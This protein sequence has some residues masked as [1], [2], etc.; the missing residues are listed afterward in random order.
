MEHED[1]SKK[2]LPLQAERKIKKPPLLLSSLSR[3]KAAE[4]FHE[5]EVHQTELELQ[6]QELREIQNLLEEARD[7]YANLFDFAPVGY[8]IL[9][10]KGII[11][12][13]NLTACNMLG[14]DRSQIKDKPF[15]SYL[16]KGESKKLHL[17]LKEVFQ[18]G[19]I[20]PFELK[21]RHQNTGDITAL[22]SGITV[23]PNHKENSIC[24]ISIQDITEIRK[25]ELLQRQNDSLVQEMENVQKYLNLAPI[26]F[27]LIDADKK[28]LMIN[29]KGCDVFGYSREE[30]LGKD[31]FTNFADL[32]EGNEENYTYY[33]FENKKLLWVPSFE[34]GVFC[35]SGERKL[36]GWRNTTIFDSSGS[37]LATLCAGQDITERKKL[38]THKNEYTEELEEIIEERTKKLREALKNER[39]L[40]ELKSSFISLA[41]HELRTPLTIVMSSIILIEKYHKAKLYN[42][43]KKHIDRIKES[44]KLFT[45]ILDDFMS[46]D[47]LERGIVIANNDQFDLME[48]LKQT[49]EEVNGICKHNQKIKIKYKGS[50]TVFTDQKILRNVLINLLSNAIKYSEKDII[51]SAKVS[52]GEI[53]IQVKDKGIGIGEEEQKYVFTRF[54]RAENTTNI[55]GTGLGLSIVKGYMEL[56]EGNIEFKSKKNK[57]STFTLIIPQEEPA[58]ESKALFNGMRLSAR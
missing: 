16:S 34:C 46:L 33:N 22:L 39:N 53:T 55:P 42:N 44:V 12:N 20:T 2:N 41:S 14:I 38:E 45:T 18:T 54:F 27:L 7:Q 8:L 52:M 32:A 6:N 50:P 51:L 48:F 57:G 23:N 47:K 9:N 11:K 17:K 49:K 5:I 10:E 25:A 3:E 29:E 24:H 31:W 56:L 40:N 58:K 43:E 30:V 19:N 35:K 26:I 4:L 21:I 13:I 36:I 1:S 15:S 37:I 28:V